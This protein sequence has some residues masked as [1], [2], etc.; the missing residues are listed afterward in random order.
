MRL[1]FYR[2]QRAR[3]TSMPVSKGLAIGLAAKFGSA[4][5]NLRFDRLG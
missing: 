2:D 4:G 1:R 3:V 5:G